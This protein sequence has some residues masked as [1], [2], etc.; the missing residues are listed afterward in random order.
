MESRRTVY[1]S[2][3]DMEPARQSRALVGLYV[4]VELETRQFNRLIPR[5]LQYVLARTCYN[6]TSRSTEFSQVWFCI[7]YIFINYCI[8]VNK[9]AVVRFSRP[10]IWIACGEWPWRTQMVCEGLWY[11]FAKRNG[12][13][14]RHCKLQVDSLISILEQKK[15]SRAGPKMG[16]HIKRCAWQVQEIACGGTHV[17]FSGI[18]KK[19]S[20]C[21]IDCAFSLQW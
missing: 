8:I 1:S 3:Q 21:K 19:L 10:A 2:I 5:S 9:S 4:Q 18:E 17:M 6:Q 15:S 11:I 20:S 13:I 7:N 12:R 14:L 16:K